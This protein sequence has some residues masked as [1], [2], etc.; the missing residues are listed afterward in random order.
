[1]RL[2]SAFV[3]GFLLAASTALAAEPPPG[4]SGPPSG[5]EQTHPGPVTDGAGHRTHGD[6]AGPQSLG[7]PPGLTRTTYPTFRSGSV[8]PDQDTEANCYILNAELRCDR[9]PARSAK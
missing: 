3:S 6:V 7:K 1:M 9:I 2:A 8:G 4:Q 5:Q